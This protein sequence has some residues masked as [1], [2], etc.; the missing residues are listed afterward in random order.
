MNVLVWYNLYLF[1]QQSDQDTKTGWWGRPWWWQLVQ[2]EP[3]HTDGVFPS[4]PRTGGGG[5]GGGVLILIFW[6]AAVVFY[7]SKQIPLCTTQHCT[8]IGI[9]GEIHYNFTTCWSKQGTRCSTWLARKQLSALVFTPNTPL[10]IT[11][12]YSSFIVHF[13][14]SSSVLWI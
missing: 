13:K 14:G 10:R 5:G 1:L 8:F 11:I 4:S 12:I 3:I 2:C 6:I 9:W 7:P